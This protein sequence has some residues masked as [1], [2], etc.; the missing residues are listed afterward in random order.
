MDQL[1][2]AMMDDYRGDPK[3]IQHFLKVYEFAR[4]MGR[5]EGLEP[6]RQA[7]LEAAAVVHDIGIHRAEQKFG[8]AAGRF[9]EREGPALAQAMLTRL[10]F[11]KHFIE[12]VCFL[13]G[14]HHTY[15]M[16]DGPDF[17]ILAE[18]DCLVNFYEDG[19]SRQGVQAA[20][21]KVFRTETGKKICRTLFLEEVRQE[22]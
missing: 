22:G 9:Q 13:V 20:M 1:I 18:A 21:D 7:I 17:Q 4:L 15:S 8:S 19:V 16:I 3:R 14:H 5:A 12:R 11:S 2:F 6:E 10:G